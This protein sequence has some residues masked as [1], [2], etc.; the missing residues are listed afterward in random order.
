LAAARTRLLSIEQITQRLQDRFQLLSARDEQ[1]SERHRSL[2]ASLHGTWEVLPRDARAT[3]EALAVFSG[4]VTLRAAERMLPSGEDD[5]WA[6]DRLEELASYGLLHRRGDRFHLL[7]S[8]QDHA[9]RKT[10]PVVRRRL[11]ELHVSTYASLPAET[12]LVDLIDDL[13]NLVVATRRAIDQGRGTEACD[14][15]WQVWRVVEARGPTEVG[16]QLLEA[17]AA[18]APPERRL[19]ALL[20]HAGA[21]LHVARTDGL[22]EVVDAILSH[23]DTRE[24][25]RA[26]LEARTALQRHQTVEAA[27][28]FERTIALADDVGDARIS[29]MARL[30]LSGLWLLENR[31]ECV[32]LVRTPPPGTS[33]SLRKLL[34]ASYVRT[35]AFL[36]QPIEEWELDEL[37]EAVR[38]QEHLPTV[39]TLLQA[40]HI[41]ALQADRDDEALEVARRV[42]QLAGALGLLR[43]IGKSAYNLSV[44]LVEHGLPEEALEAL[45][46]AEAGYRRAG[47]AKDAASCSTMRARALLV[48]D[49]LDEA[50]AATRIAIR[51][52]YPDGYWRGIPYCQLAEVLFE[53]GRREE[54]R[55]V[56]R[57]ATPLLVG[58]VWYRVHGLLAEMAAVDGR[59]DEVRAWLASGE[60]D[61]H[62]RLTRVRRHALSAWIAR[63]DGDEAGYEAELAHM[64]SL[65]RPH[66]EGERVAPRLGLT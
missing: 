3:L 53:Q 55:A 64:I 33:P 59:P 40:L 65:V 48:L 46:R 57:E 1:L 6:I 42:D 22:Q 54:A 2:L 60:P 52:N 25:D 26:F 15:A 38:N 13:D 45:D 29:V 44:Q 17:A 47:Q 41:A 34:L 16:L 10:H 43:N 20:A 23:P 11:E 21:T 62:D 8:I 56:V 18:L 32:D 50:E 30:F 28:L 37:R 36:G 63:Q 12:P 5:P 51:H 39:M 27:R 31:E 24:V 61:R 4:G 58:Q 7:V 19:K 14:L 66:T 35:R 9:T 49:R